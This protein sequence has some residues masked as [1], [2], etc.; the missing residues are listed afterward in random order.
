MGFA[1]AQPGVPSGKVVGF[2]PTSKSSTVVSPQLAGLVSSTKLI[3]D[4][5]PWFAEFHFAIALRICGPA[6]PG[7]FGINEVTNCRTLG[8]CGSAILRTR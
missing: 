2:S 5:F 8:P 4:P 1:A 3:P 7:K 6:I